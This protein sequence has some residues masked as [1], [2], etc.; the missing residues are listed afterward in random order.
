MKNFLNSL[1]DLI[2]KQRCYCCSSSVENKEFCSKCY[3]QLQQCNLLQSKFSAGVDIYCAGIYN[4]NL[5]KIIRGLKY[6]KRKNLAYYIALFMYEYW[7]QLNISGDFEIVPVPLHVDREK[8]R[9]YN[10]ALLIAEEFAKLTGYSVNTELIKRVKP[11]QPQYKLSRLERLEN[12]KDAFVVD[13]TKYNGKRLLLLDDI[14]TTAS[15]F[16][17]MIN[18]LKYNGINNILC[19]AAATP[20]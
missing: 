11:T 19:F 8:K 10:Q 12:L 14:S 6:H 13:K 9:K 1:L 4:K 3:S 15:T 16:E 17:T 18:A 5:Q 20:F 2:Y 7:Q